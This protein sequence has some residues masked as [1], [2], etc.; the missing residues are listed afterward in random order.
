MLE[1]RLPLGG[2]FI[3]RFRSL[4]GN[5]HS[6]PLTLFPIDKDEDEV[7]KRLTPSEQRE[8]HHMVHKGAESQAPWWEVSL[9]RE[10]PWWEVSLAREEREG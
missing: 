6:I 3:Q 9:A 4:K 5:S 2:L 1:I 8:F 10:E 7:W